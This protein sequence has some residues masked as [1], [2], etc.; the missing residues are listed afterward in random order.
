MP[1]VENFA[2]SQN[3]QTPS[4]IRLTDTSSGT[5]AAVTSRRVSLQTADGLYLVPV[6]NASTQYVTWA[7][8][9]SFIDIN[10]LNQDYALNIKVDWLNVSNAVLYTKTILTSTSVYSETFAF[11]L[12]QTESAAPGY[13]YDQGYLENALKLRLHI[14][15]SINAILYGG[16]IFISQAQL[17]AAQRL[18]SNASILY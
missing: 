10:A 8:V 7:I 18:I 16:N 11:A 9:N 6:G 4:V 13:L 15:N 3:V 1:L 17:N 2:I 12:A 5:D 14:D